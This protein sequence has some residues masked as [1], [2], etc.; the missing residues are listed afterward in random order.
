M[1]WINLDLCWLI[2][3]FVYNIVLTHFEIEKVLS[4]LLGKVRFKRKKSGN[5][6][7]AF[8]LFF[9]GGDSLIFR[10]CE[11]RSRNKIFIDFIRTTFA[12]HFNIMIIVF[13]QISGFFLK[14]LNFPLISAFLCVG[15]VIEKFDYHKKMGLKL[16]YER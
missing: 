9:L 4:L 7:V 11:Q 2:K 15:D 13:P 14:K 10:M 3:V 6:I 12:R 5:I 16:S 8:A 1:I